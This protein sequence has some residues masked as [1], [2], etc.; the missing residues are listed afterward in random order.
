MN[1]GW[2]L[3]IGSSLFMAMIIYFVVQ[4]FNHKTHLVS[5]DYYSEELK[6]QEQIDARQNAKALNDDMI[7]TQEN[8]Q[9]IISYPK[10]IEFGD[11]S[12]GSLHF[13]NVAQS[14]KDITIACDFSA[15]YQTLST[16]K[17]AAGRYKVKAKIN[18]NGK[19][20]FFEK[21]LTIK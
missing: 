6:F 9:L 11:A 19:A 21:N 20:Y 8:G 18:A 3:A 7:V 16:E 12:K 1:W 5:E 17:F 10:K 4:S 15:H 14:Q 2:K 13:Y